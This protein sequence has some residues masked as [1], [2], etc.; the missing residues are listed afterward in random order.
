MR[1][2]ASAPPRAVVGESRPRFFM[3]TASTP[4]PACVAAAVLVGA[5]TARAH[6]WPTLAGDPQRAASASDTPALDEPRWLRT[7]DDQNLPIHWIGQASP[8]IL[9]G[10]VFA[11]G[12][13]AGQTRLFALRFHDGDIEWDAPVDPPALDSWSSP[14]ADA[15]SNRVYIASGFGVEAFDLD[16][17]APA[18]FTPLD[19]A[20]VNASPALT[21]DRGPEDRLLITDFDGAGANAS[22]YCINLDPFDPLLNPFQPGDIVWQAPIGGASG[23]SPAVRDGVVYVATVGEA[24]FDPGQILAFDIDQPGPLTPAPLWVYTLSSLEG[25][26]GGLLAGDDEILAAT[27]TFFGGQLAG[28]LVSLDR[29]TGLEQWSAPA[30]RTSSIPV[31]LRDGLIALAAGP[32]GFGAV[33]S[34]QIF[35]DMPAGATLDADT[36]LDTHDDLNHNGLI[37]PGEFVPLGGWTH[38][39]VRLTD[40]LTP[41]LATGEPDLAPG[42][43]FEPHRGLR[44]LNLAQ[45]PASTA[46]IDEASP[47]GG[48]SPAIADGRLVSIGVTGLAAFGLASADADIDANGAVDIDDLHAFERAPV[49][50]SGDGVVDAFD[51]R[52]LLRAVRGRERDAM[53]RGLG[54]VSG[55]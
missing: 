30:N 31:R 3:Q 19:R 14:A 40:T 41:F 1:R 9:G 29:A 11:L 55:P 7:H 23:A 35:R 4:I 20:I 42:A 53:A 54:E 18:W 5:V 24:F 33:P 44:I 49:D 28:R 50:L 21:N 45:H 52:L 27:Y 16:T 15:N 25:F 46:F 6:D 2:G 22:L 8:V 32:A 39:P 26:F 47:H 51:R 17:G 48:G 13:V 38:H 37:E 43:D 36:A 10:R 12:A 34:V